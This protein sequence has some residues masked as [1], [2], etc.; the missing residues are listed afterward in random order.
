MTRAELCAPAIRA[1]KEQL[2]DKYHVVADYPEGFEVIPQALRGLSLPRCPTRISVVWVSPSP[3]TPSQYCVDHGG[4][5]VAPRCALP[6]L[7]E[8]VD[9]AERYSETKDTKPAVET[10][11]DL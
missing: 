8:M 1:A 7:R 6:H 11:L 4:I 2:A 10:G 9:R 5:T 3:S